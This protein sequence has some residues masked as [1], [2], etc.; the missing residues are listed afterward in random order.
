MLSSNSGNTQMTEFKEDGINHTEG[1]WP[2]EVDVSES[3]QV[4]NVVI[5]VHQ[6]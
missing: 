5:Y 2:K 3:D 4:L 1:G 6:Y